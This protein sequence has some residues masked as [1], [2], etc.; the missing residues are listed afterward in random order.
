MW[1]MAKK[2]IASVESGRQLNRTGPR[3]LVD[4]YVT[5][6]STQQVTKNTLKFLPFAIMHITN[7]N[8]HLYNKL[9]A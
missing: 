3:I 9:I 1:V 7:N 4:V 5:T 6:S 8:Y 2:L